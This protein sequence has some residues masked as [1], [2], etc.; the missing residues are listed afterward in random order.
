MILNN[1]NNKITIFLK[2]LI[3]LFPIL[4]I[5]GPFFLNL[6]SIIFSIYAIANYQ[7]YKK[8]EI[9]NTKIIFYFLSFIIFL[10]PFGS[11][12]FN[13]SFFKF[14]SFFRFVLMFLGLLI[15]FERENNLN[16]L[17]ITNYKIYIGIIFVIIIDVLIE[18]RF[19]Q[20]IF[21][22]KSNYGARIASFTNDE[23]IIGYIFCYIVLYSLMYIYEITNKYY[24]L[25]LIFFSFYISFI[26]GERSNFLKLF[27]LLG[28]FIIF[29]LL[30]DIK[31]N[32]KN[33]LKII[34][35]IFISFLL[36][37]Q[38]TKNISQNNKFYHVFKSKKI[39]TNL[40]INLK[41]SLYKSKHIYAYITSI[42]I[43]LDHPIFGVGINNYFLASTNEKYKDDNLIYLGSVRTVTH[44]HQ[45]YL[46][47]I[48]EVGISGAIYFIFILFYPVYVTLKLKKYKSNKYVISHLLL[49]LFFIFPI[50]PSGSI[51]GTVIGVPFWL[52]L[53]ILFYL[54][55]KKS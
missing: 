54:N 11:I 46:E 27:F 17:L 49:H 37:F 33:L 8:N 21:G 19:G 4:I 30:F 40:L 47:I 28:A 6:F 50:L 34:L 25:I 48:S 14:I 44:P 43:F 2:T 51:F 16:K 42:K 9:I 52:N 22:F 15:F 38:S 1:S 5:L 29:Y 20:N 35:L 53:A 13:N 41:E 39:E 31:K 12:E 36:L 32:I 45:T 55:N 10:F 23:L 3:I 18:F 26:I 24:F 7:K